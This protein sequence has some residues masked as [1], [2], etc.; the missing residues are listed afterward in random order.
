MVWGVIQS[1]V[2]RGL[3]METRVQRDPERAGASVAADEWRPLEGDG[4][5][6]FVIAASMAFLISVPLLGLGGLL[7]LE[8]RRSKANGERIAYQAAHAYERLV[9]APSLAMLPLESAT[10]GRDVFMSACV[11]CHGPAG[12]GIAGL[13]LNLVES[14]FVAARDDQAMVDYIIAGRPDARP[15]PMPPRAGRDD[16]NDKDL[17][18]V[19]VYLRGLQDPRRIPALPAVQSI[20]AAP[21][22]ADLQ[23]ALDAAGG[24]EELAGYIASGA[25]IFATTCAA[26]HGQGGVGIAGNGKA[27]K[28]NAFIASQSEDDL[29]DFIQRG[30][31]PGDPANTTGVGMPAKG[32]NPALSEN[33]LLDVIEYL[34]TLQSP[35]A[36]VAAAPK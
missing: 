2:I 26:C 23:A 25:K 16:L 7:V 24:D 13:G 31:D 36:D 27:L 15:T 1:H 19:V 20:V 12:T 5:R 32:G 30:R 10:H 11:A 35:E 21:T 8:A 3:T 17:A 22:E 28:N 14:D 34:R 29:F 4:W 18:D 33:D 9:A 6:E